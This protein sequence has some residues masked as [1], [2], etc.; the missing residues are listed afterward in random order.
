[1]GYGM[2]NNYIM[3]YSTLNA[4]EAHIVK[5][6]FEN[7]GIEAIVDNDKINFFFGIVSAKDA[8]IEI[9]VPEN[10]YK[11]AA[12]LMLEKSE[13]DLSKYDQVACPRC[14]EKNCGLFEYCWN[15]LANLKTGEAYMLDQTILT[16]R[17]KK[18]EKRPLSLYILI[19]L[20]ALIIA[21]YIAYF[22][23]KFI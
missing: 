14:G 15:C 1:M 21:G 3:I 23:I 19:V 2:K 9:W 16:D 7:N 6:L 13:I 11:E 4:T 17:D 22:Y 10:K 20:I 5:F 12:Q 8:M 18:Y